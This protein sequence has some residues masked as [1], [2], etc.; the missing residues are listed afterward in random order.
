M[1]ENTSPS[2]SLLSMRGTCTCTDVPLT[3]QLP[4]LPYSWWMGQ[5]YDASLLA[6]VSAA[7]C[8]L[9]SAACSCSL[10]GLEHLLR[11]G[12]WSQKLKVKIH[13]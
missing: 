5:L 9:S 11:E 7:G 1:E 4:D 6:D 12:H 3:K 8:C 10:V 2:L 13:L